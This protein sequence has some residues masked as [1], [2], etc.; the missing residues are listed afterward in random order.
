MK[1]EPVKA[2]D[3][4]LT[5]AEIAA[6]RY[7]DWSN[8]TLG[9]CVRAVAEQ[10]Q[11]EDAESTKPVTFVSASTIMVAIA[12]S[13]NATRLTYELEGVIRASDKKNMGTWVI[14]IQEKKRK[15]RKAKGT[16]A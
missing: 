14:T 6:P 8:E 2:F 5:P 4:T 7:L 12:I 11:Q 10:L 13:S 3:A 15:A 1:N 9:R 16:D